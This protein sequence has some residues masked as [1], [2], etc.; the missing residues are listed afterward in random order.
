MR[1]SPFVLVASCLILLVAT[2][3]SPQGAV[4]RGPEGGLFGP[5]RAEVDARDRLTF[6]FETA[7]G[8]DT[9]LPAEF[10]SRVPQE[11]QADGWSTL[12]AA[13]SQYARRGR[14]LEIAGTA[15]SA[16]RYYH[17]IGRL[18]TLSH[19][20]GLGFAVKLPKQGNFRVD[21]TAAYSPSYLYQL[22]PVGTPPSL[23]ASIPTNP[24]Y[25]VAENRSYTYRS[26]AALSFG[27]RLGTMVTTSGEFNRTEFEQQFATR[28]DL[29]FYDVGATV[30]HAQGRNGGYSAGYHYR[31]GQFGFGGFTTE[32]SVTI[33]GEYSPA[34]SRTRRAIFRLNLTPARLDLPVAA[35]SRIT[36]GEPGGPLYRLN[37][38]ASVSYPF[39]V[40]WRVAATYRRDVEYLAVLRQPVFSDGSRV[41]LTGLIS[42]RLD[43]SALAGYA[44][45]A[46]VLL[47]NGGRN[48]ETYTGEVK[49]RYAL[50]RSFALYTAYLYYHYDL[51]GQAFLAP[52]LPSVFEQHGA[53]VGFML[54]LDAL[55]K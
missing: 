43:L 7:E 30:A 12:F 2:P 29:E 37:G 38:D 35:L 28:L 3:A 42:R 54:F 19:A 34:L 6:T 5:T 44:T 51:R 25:R 18:N 11:L 8:F 15:S 9:E 39:R 20:A 45:G 41:E 32:H 40:N 48:L 47:L 46:S 53:R 23:G 4:P 16:I 14:I 24:E 26:S 1:R 50:K 49:L 33:G 36:G 52:D 17:E 13:S 27:S 31:A 22:F 21:S 10:R 55:G